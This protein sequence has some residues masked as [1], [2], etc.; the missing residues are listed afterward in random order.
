MGQCRFM[1]ASRR[2]GGFARQGRSFKTLSGH[3]CQNRTRPGGRMGGKRF[4]RRDQR[5]RKRRDR[6][7]RSCFLVARQ[8]N[9]GRCRSATNSRSGGELPERSHSNN[10][11]P[12]TG[13]ERNSRKGV[14]R[15]LSGAGVYSRL[16]GG[17][18]GE[19]VPLYFKWKI[20]G[21]PVNQGNVGLPDHAADWSKTE[22]SGFTSASTAAVIKRD[23]T[24]T[25]AN[26]AGCLTEPRVPTVTINPTPV[27]PPGTPKICAN[28]GGIT[29]QSVV[30]ES[31]IAPAADNPWT[32]ADGGDFGTILITPGNG[33][34]ATVT[35]V[36]RNQTVAQTVTV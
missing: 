7:R 10:R 17:G 21:N 4:R 2:L 34:R 11:S 31:N 20:E 23:I 36:D 19:S 9:R 32:I 26:T 27:I 35:A 13:D 6:N 24:I 3:P 16:R 8:G 15:Q 30:L 33:R 12:E 25:R 22:V 14:L 5:Y 1:D 29:P 18:T 28:A